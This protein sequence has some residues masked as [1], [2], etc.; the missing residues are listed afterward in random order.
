MSIRWKPLRFKSLTYSST[1]RESP[2][3]SA[4][5]RPDVSQ[6]SCGGTDEFLAGV[7]KPISAQSTVQVVVT[8]RRIG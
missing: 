2:V 5:N 8:A 7:S 1:P 4:Q 3:I 6:I